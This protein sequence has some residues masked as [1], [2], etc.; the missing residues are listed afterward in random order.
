MRQHPNTDGDLKRVRDDVDRQLKDFIEQ[1][2]TRARGLDANYG[3][4]WSV[5][6]DVSFSGGKRFRPYMTMLAYQ[7]YGGDDYHAVIP[8]AAAQEL[9]H[10]S[11]LIHDDIIDRD[12]MRH[13]TANVA[14][15]YLEEYST[16][17]NDDDERRHFANS[18]SLLAGDLGLSGAYQ[19]IMQS[20]LSSDKKLTAQQLLGDTVFVLCGGELLDT[21]SSFRNLSQ[22]D[23]IKNALLKTSSYSFVSPLT[24]GA[25]MA[26]APA[27]EIARLRELGDAL[28]IAYQIADD[29]LGLYG[30]E[31]VTG[32]SNIGDLREGK[33]TYLVMKA[34]EM[35]GGDSSELM[36]LLGKPDIT[37]AEA[38]RAK[39]II[40]QS[41]A[42]AEAEQL[43]IG[44]TETARPIV[45]QLSIAVEYR[46]QFAELINRATQRSK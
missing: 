20:T 24:V 31:A 44:Y 10:I 6:K 28:G 43:I 45:E 1:R 16:Y 23:P 19:L 34:L 37:P 13:G 33:R 26:D 30:D 3:K 15:S 25:S 41:G 18:A 35:T 40:E 14:G 22:I 42:K 39:K 2:Q 5:I 8:I 17:L 27:K 29:L 12:Y 9:L 4:L 21:E 11:M 38:E 32:K 46:Q 36:P 7:A